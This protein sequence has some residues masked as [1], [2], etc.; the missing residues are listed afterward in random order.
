MTRIIGLALLCVLALDATAAQ[1]LDLAK[2]EVNLFGF[3]DFNYVEDEG[4]D[5][6]FVMGQL[7]GH[8]SAGLGERFNLF[9]EISA[10]ARDDEYNLEVERLFVR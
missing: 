5:G 9:S 1:T 3:G 2:R 6:G 10:T 4:D 7:V 8:L